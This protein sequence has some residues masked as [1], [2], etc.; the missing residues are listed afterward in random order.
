MIIIIMI[1]IC[2][3]DCWRINLSHF[4]QTPNMAV[5]MDRDL[6]IVLNKYFKASRQ[7]SQI[8]WKELLCSPRRH[9]HD[10]PRLR[11]RSDVN[12]PRL[13]E[14]L[15]SCSN[16]REILTGSDQLRLSS[17]AWMWAEIPISSLQLSNYCLFYTSPCQSLSDLIRNKGKKKKNV[18]TGLGLKVQVKR[19]PPTNHHRTTPP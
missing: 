16:N 1:V 9:G 5:W 17:S 14:F 10:S 7:S 3:V 18:W 2:V 15:R 6:S 12:V 8:I 19:I 4:L 13:M 11:F